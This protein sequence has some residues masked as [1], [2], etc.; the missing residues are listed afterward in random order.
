MRDSE[1]FDQTVRKF[2]E[3]I[4]RSL[5]LPLTKVED[6]IYEIPSPHFILRIRLDTGHARGMN[7]MLR[8]ASLHNFDENEPGVHYG[9]GCFIQFHGERLEDTF[10]E[11]GSDEAFLEQ[12]RLL[13]KATERY[14]IPYL[15]G[16]GK[17]WEAVKQMIAAK[18]EKDVEEIQKYKFPPFVQ[19]RWHLP[20]P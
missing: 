1:L 3:P 20:K 9:I 4:A 19:K 12:A 7:A 16:Q 8:P 10:I 11:V 17:E 6:G 14:G 13:A 15:L 2:F 5:T 18:T